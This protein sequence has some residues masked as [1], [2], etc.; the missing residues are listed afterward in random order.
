MV[1]KHTLLFE[2][3]LFINHALCSLR[4]Y[5]A[6]LCLLTRFHGIVLRLLIRYIVHLS[7]CRALTYLDK[8]I[9]CCFPK[10][11]FIT[12]G[13]RCNGR[14]PT[15]YGRWARQLSIS[16]W[17][18]ISITTYTPQCYFCWAPVNII[19]SRMHRSRML[20]YKSDSAVTPLYE[21]SPTTVLEALK[22][23]LSWFSNQVL[24]KKHYQIC[25]KHFTI[26]YYTVKM[27]SQ[28]SMMK[29]WR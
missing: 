15:K 5:T 8:L 9:S 14:Q 29:P 18:C 1:I 23:Q 13:H 16:S 12:G 24:V 17:W 3:T 26:R 19:G 21:N 11:Q 22:H 6:W 25:C 20:M 27:L 7:I 10:W 28:N 4:L 2:F